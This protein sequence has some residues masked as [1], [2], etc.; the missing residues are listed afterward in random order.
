M[1]CC[2]TLWWKC[3]T[4][5]QRAETGITLTHSLTLTG[6]LIAIQFDSSLSELLNV[7]EQLK[8]Q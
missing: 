2:V 4:P 3:D 6:H 1:E 7:A 5:S 8:P